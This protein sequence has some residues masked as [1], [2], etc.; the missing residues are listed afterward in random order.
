MIVYAIVN[1]MIVVNGDRLVSVT[2]DQH[3][4]S[5]PPAVGVWMED[6]HMNTPEDD[7]TS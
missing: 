5:L 2:P 1:Y 4:R 3:S 7:H 6:L